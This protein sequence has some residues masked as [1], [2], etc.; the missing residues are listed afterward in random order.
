M[1]FTLLGC[2]YNGV[3]NTMLSDGPILSKKWKD[4]GLKLNIDLH[5][6][7]TIERDFESGKASITMALTMLLIWWRSSM[8]KE[9]TMQNL[10]KLLREMKWDAIAGDFN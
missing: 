9:A 10:I 5:E 4:L 6:L 3:V 2:S 8:A 1:I 7:F